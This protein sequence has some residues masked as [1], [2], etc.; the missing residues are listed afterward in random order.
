MNFSWPM[1]DR[2][3]WDWWMNIN[4]VAKAFEQ[5]CSAVT[6]R[7]TVFIITI[8]V[9]KKEDDEKMQKYSLFT[10]LFLVLCKDWSHVYCLSLF[11]GL[12][13]YVFILLIVASIFSSGNRNVEITRHVW[14]HASKALIDVLNFHRLW[15]GLIIWVLCNVLQAFVFLQLLKEEC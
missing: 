4:Q 2:L 7:D 6:D 12:L 5:C 9:V 13:K 11:D 14:L 8:Q 3:L 1:I 10:H 15:I